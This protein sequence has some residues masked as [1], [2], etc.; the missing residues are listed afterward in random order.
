MGTTNQKFS[1]Q[2]SFQAPK[3]LVFQA[4]STE[5]ALAE[6][7]GPIGVSIEVIRLDFKVNGVFHYKMK[8]DEEHYG[9]FLF[10]EIERPNRITWINSFADKN[11]TIIKPPFE[12]LDLPKAILNKISLEEKNGIT[13]ITLVSEPINSTESETATF[14]SIMEGM[15]EGWGGTFDKLESYLAKIGR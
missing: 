15:E 10:K 12:G 14:Y 7:W 3:E 6:W 4:F 8:G 1:V 13:T 11:G 2:R 9:L 5:D